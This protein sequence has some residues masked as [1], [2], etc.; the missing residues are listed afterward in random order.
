MKNISDYN[1]KVEELDRCQIHSTIGAAKVKFSELHED[2]VTFEGDSI[3]DIL[4]VMCLGLY[5]KSFH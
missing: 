1:H 4:V 3:L 5:S 2:I